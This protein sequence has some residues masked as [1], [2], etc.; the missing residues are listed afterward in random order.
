[1]GLDK[2]EIKELDNR[3]Q[4]IAI[5]L[6]KIQDELNGISKGL[7]QEYADTSEGTPDKRLKP[8]EEP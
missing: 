2:E 4:A 6:D 7:K 1:M 5:N 8:K 3:I